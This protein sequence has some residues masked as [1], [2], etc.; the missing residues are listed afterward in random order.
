MAAF[1][2]S[3]LCSAASLSACPTGSKHENSGDEQNSKWQK[4]HRSRWRASRSEVKWGSLH[5]A[6]GNKKGIARD[7][8]ELSMSSI[9][10]QPGLGVSAG[11]GKARPPRARHR[12]TLLEEEMGTQQAARQPLPFEPQGLCYSQGSCLDGRTP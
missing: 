11:D 1:M 7:R 3:V 10:F 9:T 2:R 5:F 12:V 4:P 6:E 8:H